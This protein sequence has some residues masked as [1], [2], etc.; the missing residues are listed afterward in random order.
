MFE[1]IILWKNNKKK[2]VLNNNISLLIWKTNNKQVNEKKNI[3]LYNYIQKL[4]KF[5]MLKC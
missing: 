1:N 3:Y 2:T 5:P 4:K